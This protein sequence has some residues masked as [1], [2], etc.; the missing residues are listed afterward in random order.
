MH[1][2][3]SSGTWHC[4]WL[5]RHVLCLNVPSRHDVFTHS[6]CEA[7]LCSLTH[8]LVDV[9]PQPPAL[10]QRGVANSSEEALHGGVDVA[11]LLQLTL[12]H[13]RMHVR[14]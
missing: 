14:P 11:G 7:W 2:T 4:K 9:A 12:L 1:I 8:K 13:A 5:Q 6:V 3:K 10:P